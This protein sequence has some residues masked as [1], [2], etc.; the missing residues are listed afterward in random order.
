MSSIGQV[1]F[2]F[3][4]ELLSGPRGVA[5]LIVQIEPGVIQ[6]VGDLQAALPA[7][8]EP[9]LCLEEIVAGHYP[10][11]EEVLRH[12]EVIG[13]LRHFFIGGREE[14]LFLEDAEIG[15]HRPEENVLFLG[16]VVE[17]SRVPGRLGL[18]GAG[19]GAA[20][21]VEGFMER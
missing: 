14:F 2:S 13:H 16:P 4:Y 12:A 10:L 3:F 19:V 1:D 7:A 11:L 9:H 20:E 6:P 18:R 5:N 17:A 21:V 15:N 8:G